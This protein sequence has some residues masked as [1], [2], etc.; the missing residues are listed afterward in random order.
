MQ[1]AL[2]EKLQKQVGDL[3][4]AATKLSI[5]LAKDTIEIEQCQELFR[6]VTDARNTVDETLLDRRSNTLSEF[7]RA[8][9]AGMLE[10]QANMDAQT[11]RDVKRRLG[12][13]ACGA[14]RAYSWP[15]N[16]RELKS[17]IDRAHIMADGDT[18]G[19]TD[20]ALTPE[21]PE[22]RSSASEELFMLNHADAVSAFE[23]HYFTHLLAQHPTRIKAALAAN[24]ST[25]GLR[26]ALRRLHIA[27]PPTR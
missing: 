24:M 8:V 19:A 13:E 11:A 10:A 25:E 6:A 22:R 2:R 4:T 23:R 14:L 27:H 20:L 9:G 12:A 21:D 16:V 15:G 7:F 17:V 18:I 1:K 3:Q 5:N 26:L